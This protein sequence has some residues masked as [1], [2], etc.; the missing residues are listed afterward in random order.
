MQTKCS[1]TA[2]LQHSEY[3]TDTESVRKLSHTRHAL[4]VKDRSGMLFGMSGAMEKC[5]G[6]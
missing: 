5:Y 1:K 6:M 2:R 4:L 3:P